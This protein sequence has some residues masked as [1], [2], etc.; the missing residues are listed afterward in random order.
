[1]EE[2]AFLYVY[3]MIYLDTILCNSES[4][5][6]SEHARK[7]LKRIGSPS[8]PLI[9]CTEIYSESK[10]TYY[11]YWRAE[12][13]F[14]VVICQILYNF[15][16]SLESLK[17]SYSADISLGQHGTQ[18]GECRICLWSYGN[19][20]TVARIKYSVLQNCNLN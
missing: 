14:W 4:V 9:Y 11:T 3:S 8:L 1:M 15:S 2:I 17:F 7:T 12:N 13:C 6:N 18:V 16:F 10:L 20:V 5:H 19:Q